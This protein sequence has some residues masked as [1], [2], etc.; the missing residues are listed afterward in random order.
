VGA[1]KSV[2][3]PVGIGGKGNEGVAGVVKQTPGAI[4]YVEL[5]YAVQNKI[6][7]AEVRNRS[8][9]FVMPTIEST[10]AAATG[11]VDSMKKDIRTLIVDSRAKGA[12]PISGFTYILLYNKQ[13]DHVKGANLVKFLQWAMHDGQKMAKSLLYAP[14]PAK[15]VAIN[16]AAL[17]SVH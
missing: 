16:E 11:A 14:L 5:A 6:A 1:G 2:N 12:Y 15:V 13:T 10:T 3:W 8:G 7:Y 17:K 9:E 4:G